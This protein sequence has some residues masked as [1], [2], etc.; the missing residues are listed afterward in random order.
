M[1]HR[2]RAD[3]RAVAQ[4]R[5]NPRPLALGRHAGSQTS[6]G[7]TAG[8]LTAP[9]LREHSTPAIHPAA[10]TLPLRRALSLDRPDALP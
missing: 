3:E 9:G 2:V 7:L 4:Q 10:G 6:P 1:S 8:R 5:L